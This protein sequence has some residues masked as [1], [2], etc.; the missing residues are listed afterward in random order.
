MATNVAT[1]S[2]QEKKCIVHERETIDMPAQE[3]K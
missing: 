1:E 3:A 2:P